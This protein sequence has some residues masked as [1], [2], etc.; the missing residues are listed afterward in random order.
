MK[1]LSTPTSGFRI[2]ANRNTFLAIYV[3][4]VSLLTLTYSLIISFSL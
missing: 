2:Q 1:T 3:G 4:V